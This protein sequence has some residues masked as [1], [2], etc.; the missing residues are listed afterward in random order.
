MAGYS[1]S[2]ENS[3]IVRSKAEGGLPTA[4]LPKRHTECVSALVMG[5]PH[6]NNVLKREDLK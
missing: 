5:E 3:F 4:E 6:K 2:L 1:C